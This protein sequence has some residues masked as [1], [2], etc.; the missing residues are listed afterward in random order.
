MNLSLDQ[1]RRLQEIDERI[2]KVRDRLFEGLAGEAKTLA[3]AEQLALMGER[4]VLREEL[5][6]A[7]KPLL[8]DIVPSSLGAQAARARIKEI[9]ETPGYLSFARGP[10]GDNLLTEEQR[11]ALSLELAG[12]QAA[13]LE[14]K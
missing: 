12:L 5:G 14:D 2:A 1:I 13:L 7:P 8:P 6:L 10:T 9:R 3:V 11:R 4:Q